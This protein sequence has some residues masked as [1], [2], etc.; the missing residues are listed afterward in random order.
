[1]ELET[2]IVSSANGSA[3]VRM[4]GDIMLLLD[5][6]IIFVYSVHDISGDYT[7]VSLIS[8]IIH[9]HVY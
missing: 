4:V 7:Y 6:M 2:D 1:M 5:I 8:L 3:R 9:I